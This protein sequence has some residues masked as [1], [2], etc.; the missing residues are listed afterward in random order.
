MHLEDN[1]KDGT[2][3]HLIILC[4]CSKKDLGNASNIVLSKLVYMCVLWMSI[5]NS[6]KTI[7]FI[8]LSTKICFVDINLSFQIIL[9]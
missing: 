1:L 3:L 9:V 7:D 4:S 8:S 2:F 6:I 5:I